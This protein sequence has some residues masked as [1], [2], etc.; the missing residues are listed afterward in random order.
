MSIMWNTPH[1]FILNITLDKQEGT[2]GGRRV[3]MTFPLLLIQPWQT[4]IVSCSPSTG[5]YIQQFP[6]NH[7]QKWGWKYICESLNQSNRRFVSN[8]SDTEEYFICCSFLGQKPNQPTKSNTCLFN[9]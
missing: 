2:N 8:V 1:K 7:S 5:F 4:D 6:F 3:E 9:I